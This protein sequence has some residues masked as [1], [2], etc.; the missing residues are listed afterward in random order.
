MKTA[1][2]TKFVFMTNQEVNTKDPTRTLTLRNRWSQD[3]S[4]RLKKL[5]AS[6][7]QAVYE[8]DI[9]GL[10]E[11]NTVLGLSET[12]ERPVTNITAKAFAFDS[13]ANKIKNFVEWL[14]GQ[15][16]DG[17]LEVIPGPLG[18]EPWSNTYVRSSY[19]KG[20]AQARTRLRA[21]G[22]PLA[23]DTDIFGGLGAAFNHPFHIDRVNLI[24]TRSFSGLNGIT[25]FIDSTMSREL[26]NGLASGVGPLQ[27]ARRLNNVI[28][29]AGKSIPQGWYKGPRGITRA[30][31]L[32]RTETTHA[33]N[34]AHLMEFDRVAQ[35]IGEPVL[36]EWFTA[37]DERVRDSHALRHG[38][39]YKRAEAEGLI[40]EPNCRCTLVPFIKSIDSKADKKQ[41]KKDRKRR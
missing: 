25:S 12:N 26:A 7:R 21:K 33:Y 19:Q 36:S 6:I 5:N 34:E 41:R 31:L 1:T 2:R 16:D 13:D 27:M 14:D 38:Q 22:I 40:G 8:L 35:D 28:E 15:Y 29:K 9:F 39:I 37:G 11:P 24:Y 4:A 30:R 3:A 20:L 10:G 18:P 17:I 32:A 23:A